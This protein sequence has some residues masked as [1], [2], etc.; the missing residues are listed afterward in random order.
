MRGLREEKVQGGRA[1]EGLRQIDRVIIHAWMPDPTSRASADRIDHLNYTQMRNN[2][3]Y[4]Q[5][6]T[7]SHTAHNTIVINVNVFTLRRNRNHLGGRVSSGA[8][9]R[10]HL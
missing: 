3:S 6:P 4:T 9:L 8:Y 10:V 2:E 5:K 7:I 1:G